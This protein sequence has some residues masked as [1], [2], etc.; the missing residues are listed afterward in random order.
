MKQVQAIAFVVTYRGGSQDMDLDATFKL[1]YK[2]PVNVEEKMDT[3]GKTAEAQ[4]VDTVRGGDDTR[5]SFSVPWQPGADD[6]QQ[7]GDISWDEQRKR[8]QTRIA[9]CRSDYAFVYSC[10]HTLAL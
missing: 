2:V 1:G 7:T 8:K 10:I 9:Y 4:C 6:Q 5:F 3:D